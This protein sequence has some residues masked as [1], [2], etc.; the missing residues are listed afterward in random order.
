MLLNKTIL[1]SAAIL[2]SLTLVSCSSPEPEETT[3]VEL[4]SSPSPTASESPEPTETPTPLP[5][6]PTDGENFVGNLESLILYTSNYV[7]LSQLNTDTVQNIILRP[8]ENGNPLQWYFTT[9]KNGYDY[10]TSQL[11][12]SEGWAEAQLEGYGEEDMLGNI[13]N[14]LSFEITKTADNEYSVNI[15]DL[16]TPES[17]ENN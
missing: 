1:A 16:R 4:S 3:T 7:D 6:T 15:L 12:N 5:E 10:L 11:R 2:L 14:A 9:D 13:K 17:E 8:E